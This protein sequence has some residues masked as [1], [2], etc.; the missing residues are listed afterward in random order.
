ME[1]SSN[2]KNDVWAL[3]VILYMMLYNKHPLSGDSNSL[4][5]LVANASKLLSYNYE[6]EAPNNQPSFIKD[7]L[8]KTLSGREITRDPVSNI[9]FMLKNYFEQKLKIQ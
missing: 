7:L 2:E 6:I 9:V 4:D 3:G 5:V 8:S 1:P